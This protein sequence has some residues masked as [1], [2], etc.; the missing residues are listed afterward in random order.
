MRKEVYIEDKSYG[1]LYQSPNISDRSYVDTSSVE[2]VS[3]LSNALGKLAKA[4]F[5]LGTLAIL[6]NFAPSA[7]YAITGSLN[8]NKTEQYLAQ[9]AELAKNKV[10]DPRSSYQP[11]FDPTLP[12]E[13]QVKITS[14]GISGLVNEASIENYEDALKKGVWRVSD[15]GTPYNRQ[16]PTILVAHRFGYLFWSNQMR[17]ENSFYNLPNLEEGD[18]IEV[19]WN[20]RKYA[21][22]VYGSSR[23]EEITDYSA[24]LIL[25]TCESLN[26]PVRIFR[27]AKLLEI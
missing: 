24:D 17:R 6:V 14:I 18:R 1:L 19:I 3:Y 15:F 10:F 16:K 21:Y 7:L 26:T 12:K 5:V 23:G 8:S 25:Y 27:Y 11:K 20:Q 13:P 4:T 22:E 9:T 2:N